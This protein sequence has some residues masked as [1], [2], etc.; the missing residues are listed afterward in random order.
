MGEVV[1]ISVT[2]VENGVVEVPAG[3][4]YGELVAYM[5]KHRAY[6]NDWDDDGYEYAPDPTESIGPAV[7]SVYTDGWAHNGWSAWAMGSDL[8]TITAVGMEAIREPADV[9]GLLRTFADEAKHCARTPLNPVYRPWAEGMVVAGIVHN[10][11]QAL[12]VWQRGK[13]AAVI[14]AVLPDRYDGP[15]WVEST[16]EGQQL[17]DSWRAEVTRG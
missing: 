4:T 13:L 15:L 5:D 16:D 11:R 14:M 8:P 6:W 12:L 7:T 17:L 2:R 1:L 3:L 9:A 10:G